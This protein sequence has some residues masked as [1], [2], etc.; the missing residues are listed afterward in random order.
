MMGN[1][2]RKLLARAGGS[3]LAAK[4]GAWPVSLLRRERLLS[5]KAPRCIGC[6]CLLVGHDLRHQ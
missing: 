6:A 4:L 2:R 5:R 1:H 3:A